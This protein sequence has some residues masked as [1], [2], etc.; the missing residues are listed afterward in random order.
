MIEGLGIRVFQNSG[1]LV[2]GPHT[3]DYNILGFY[4]EVPY[5]GK[6]PN[7][8]QATSAPS[9]NVEDSVL[10]SFPCNP[11]HAMW[12]YIY[13]HIHT[14][15]YKFVYIYVVHCSPKP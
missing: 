8:V 5:P 4:I 13:I 7:L 11:E 9:S 14:Y 15:V 12:N 6:L 1:S 10:L 3:K 2:K